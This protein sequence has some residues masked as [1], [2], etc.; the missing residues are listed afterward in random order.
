[1]RVVVVSVAKSLSALETTIN[2]E[3]TNVCIWLCANRSLLNIDKSNCFVS[4]STK[5]YSKIYCSFSLSLNNHQFKREY[6]IK[7]LGLMIDSV[8]LKTL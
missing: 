5:K 7:Y 2:C 4:S 3:L 8:S 6:C 1:M